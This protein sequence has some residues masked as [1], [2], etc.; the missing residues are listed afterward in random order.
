MNISLAKRYCDLINGKELNKL[1]LLILLWEKL[2]KSKQ[3]Q[4]KYQTKII[5]DKKEQTRETEKQ[6]HKHDDIKE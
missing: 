1:N 5:K 6:L 2:L 4:T 3:K